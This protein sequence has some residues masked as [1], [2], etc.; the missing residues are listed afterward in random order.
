M[1]TVDEKKLN[2][3]SSETK[4]PI[5]IIFHI[6]HLCGDCTKYIIKMVINLIQSRSSCEAEGFGGVYRIG[7]CPS[8]SSVA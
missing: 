4:Q 2:V 1:A 5:L 7:S 6:K 3:I 8:S